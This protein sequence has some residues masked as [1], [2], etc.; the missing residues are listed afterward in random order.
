MMSSF[1]AYTTI[2]LASLLHLSSTT[3][4]S[5]PGHN[6]AFVSAPGPIPFSNPTHGGDWPQGTTNRWNG[7]FPSN[8]LTQDDFAKCLQDYGSGRFYDSW[9]G[10]VCGGLGWYKGA[11]NDKIGT[12]DCYQ[13]CA[14]WLLYDG[15][16]NRNG[17]YLCDYRKG[18]SGHC[19]M[20]YHRLPKN[21]G[22]GTTAEAAIASA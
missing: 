15:A 17:D 12:Y 9:D 4:M 20:G 11:A 14:T 1:P 6:F 2:M 21:N 10:N 8:E 3:P 22:N 18:I 5:A 7:G 16:R 19:W 13:T